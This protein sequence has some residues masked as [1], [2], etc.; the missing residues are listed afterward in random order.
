MF[1][2]EDGKDIVKVFGLVFLI[3]LSGDIKTQPGPVTPARNTRS[4]A[5]K[6]KDTDKTSSGI[7]KLAAGQSAICK[8][9]D[10]IMLKLDKFD[11]AIEDLKTELKSIGEKQQCKEKDLESAK[12]NICNNSS[13]IQD[14]ECMMYKHEQYSRKSFVQIIGVR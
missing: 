4:A 14:M 6:S 7:E 5:A 1:N 12:N 3:L 9:L 10:E 11:K 2:R 8:A 13:G